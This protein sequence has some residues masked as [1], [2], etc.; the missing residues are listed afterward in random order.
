MIEE[1]GISFRNMYLVVGWI[2]C[3]FLVA[4]KLVDDEFSAFC[5]WQAATVPL[6]I[7][8]ACWLSDRPFRKMI[9]ARVDRRH[10]KEKTP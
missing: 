7:T 5:S 6:W 8:V 4:F 2:A 3:L 10:E 1:A 9:R